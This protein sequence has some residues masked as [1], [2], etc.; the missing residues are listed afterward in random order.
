MDTSHLANPSLRHL[1][2]K[3]LESSVDP[4]PLP[5]EDF[6]WMAMY[7]MMNGILSFPFTS[8]GLR[9]EP[10]K[11]ILII[12]RY[13]SGLSLSSDHIS[14]IRINLASRNMRLR[15][16]ASFD[17]SIVSNLAPS[18]SNGQIT[19]S[20]ISTLGSDL[21]EEAE[22]IERLKYR[23]EGSRNLTSLQERLFFKRNDK[24]S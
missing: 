11:T 9:Y 22:L 13:P 24:T 20:R 3:V 7:E 12:Q 2:F 15:S 18:G 10:T 19:I 5:P 16:L 21:Q 6:L 8:Y 1:S 4:N 23:D 17:R 14:L